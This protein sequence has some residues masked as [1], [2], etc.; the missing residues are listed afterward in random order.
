MESTKRK[1]KWKKVED[2]IRAFLKLKYRLVG[3]KVIKEDDPSLNFPRPSQPIMNCE[4]VK[5]VAE[6]LHP[7]LITKEDEACPSAVLALGYN[8][9]GKSKNDLTAELSDVKA[10]AL[11]PLDNSEVTPDVIIAILTPSQMADLAASVHSKTQEP[12]TAQFRGRISCAEYLALP[13]MNERANVTFMCQGGRLYAGY[14]DIELLFGSPPST[15]IEAAE[16]MKHVVQLG[17][18]LCGCRTSDLPDTMR[19]SFERI[20]LSKGIDYFFGKV[21]AHSLR[22]YLNKDFQGNYRFVTIYMPI[23]M[24]SHEEAINIAEKLKP[25]LENKPYTAKTRGYWLDITITSTADALSLDLET[26]ENLDFAL[27]RISENMILHLK[28]AGYVKGGWDIERSR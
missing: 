24:A 20:G 18:A 4:A 19:F 12:I 16:T 3:V 11:F 13:Y 23:R 8:R 28:Q 17:G 14:K 27:K 15:Y 2:I 6:E 9:T 21:N 5:K 1:I 7:L 25:I 10:I 26:G 22:V